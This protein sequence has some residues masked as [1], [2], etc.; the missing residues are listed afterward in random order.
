MIAI[1]SQS[2]QISS[3]KGREGLITELLRPVAS[4]APSNAPH[5]GPTAKVMTCNCC[6]MEDGC[7]GFILCSIRIAIGARQ[8]L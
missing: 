4:M 8:I 1:T 6:N 3:E 7:E 2:R 5:T